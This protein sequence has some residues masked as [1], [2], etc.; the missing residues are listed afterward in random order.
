[1]YIHKKHYLLKLFPLHLSRDTKL[2]Q[3]VE[4]HFSSVT[5]RQIYPKCGALAPL[6]LNANKISM[7]FKYPAAEGKPHSGAI[8]SP[9]TLEALEKV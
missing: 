7:A 9:G 3:S 5:D 1:V 2:R 8:R 4:F 6:A